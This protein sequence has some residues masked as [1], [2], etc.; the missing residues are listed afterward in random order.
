MCAPCIKKEIMARA[1]KISTASLEK[2]LRVL[3]EG[4]KLNK[5]YFIKTKRMDKD[6]SQWN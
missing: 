6:I 3:M 1:V 4:L 2:F 5:M